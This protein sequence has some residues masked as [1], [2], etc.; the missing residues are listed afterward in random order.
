MAT[1]GTCKGSG[2]VTCDTCGGIGSYAGVP[3]G[4]DALLQPCPTCEGKGRTVCLVRGWT[5][6]RVD[7]DD[8]LRR[9]SRLELEAELI[10][11]RGHHGGDLFDRRLLSRAATAFPAQIDVI[12]TR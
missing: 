7:H 9:T 11:Q 2:R 1:C 8:L 4:V 6:Y 5:A 3:L 10:L 12:G